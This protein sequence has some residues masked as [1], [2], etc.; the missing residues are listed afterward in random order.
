[1]LIDSKNRRKLLISAIAGIVLLVLAA[2]VLF[3]PFQPGVIANVTDSSGTLAPAI[4]IPGNYPEGVSFADIV[5]DESLSDRELFDAYDHDNDP[6]HPV[7]DVKVKLSISSLGSRPGEPRP[8]DIASEYPRQIAEPTAS[9]TPVPTPSATLQPGLVIPGLKP[10]ISL[11]NIEL[12]DLY[13]IGFDIENPKFTGDRYPLAWGYTAGRT[14][15]FTVSLSVDGGKSF[16]E[17]ATKLTEK[18]YELTFPG[19][20]SNEC[21][22]RVT[23][24]LDGIIYKIADTDKFA[25]LAAPEPTP[26][27]IKDYIDPQVQYI[28]LPGMRIN[29]ASGLPV[30]F[31]AE[32]EV[33]NAEKL[34]WQLAKDPFW[35]TKESFGSETGIIADG[36][37]DRAQGGEFSVDLKALCEELTKPSGSAEKPFLV[38][39]NIYM[40]YMRVVALDQDGNCIGDPGRGIS[41]SYGVPDVVADLN[42]TSITEQSQ[43]DVL[44][45]MFYDS[46]YQWRRVS[47]DVLNRSLNSPPDSLLFGGL[48]GSQ[49]GSDIIKNA[50]QVEMQVATSP[51]SDASSMGLAKP[52]GLVYSYLDT[53]PDIGQSL[54][55]Y[56]YST[57]NFHGIEYD[58]FVPSQAD[59]DAMGGIYYYVRALFYVPDSENPSI[60]HPYS[61]ETLTIAYR[62]TSADQNKVEEVVVKSNI[63]F[64]QFLRYSPVRW[65]DPNYEEYFEV[66]RHI[67]AEEMN[68]TIRNKVTGDFL[69]P[70]QDHI[71]QYKWTRE[72]YQAKLD[73]M[74]PMYTSFRY[75]KSEP[76]GFWDEFFSLLN[77]I[78][79]SVQQAYADAKTSVAGLVDY[80]PLIGEDAKGYLKTAIKYAIDYGLASIGLPPGLPNLDKLADGGLDYCFKVAVDEALKQAGVPVDSE[81]AQEITEK[82]RK[83][84][85]DG[86]SNELTKSLLAQYQNPFHADFVRVNTYRLYEPAFVDVLIAN[87]SDTKN[88]AGGTLGLTFGDHSEIYRSSCLAIP[89]L[90]PNDFTIV[91]V[92]LEH[93]RNKYDGYGKYFDEIYYGTSGEPFKMRVYTSFDLKDVREAAKEQGLSPAPLPAVTQFVYDHGNYEFTRSFVPSEV[94]WD[95]D[96]SVD[97]KAFEG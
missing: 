85:T 18:K 49:Q 30:W 10:G 55:G 22:L 80:I 34:I 88:S 44:V 45:Y 19:T 42:S 17:L 91:R 41:F 66:T 33:E 9:P 40:F 64:V 7:L 70:Y 12:P 15:V 13:I 67:E 8:Q 72:Q 24:V 61:S 25:L 37:V 84:I 21:I 16:K 27:L 77:S 2:L 73:Q 62:V 6:A 29:S 46:K 81:A 39:Q 78:Y 47:P 3:K 79:S 23:A 5:T 57:P 97:P 96:S 87:Y 28:D 90:K 68:F 20:P 56:N 54:D 60:L 74:L 94:I 50:V 31:K 93:E 65:Q 83:Q 43:I 38:K 75:L 95:E 53:A 69:L 4:Y 1:M 92:Y 89:T 11:P 82:V 59:L 71:A 52:N 14:V 32:S 48:D 51:F 35:G 86:I 76:A 63:P 26:T 58:K 36:D